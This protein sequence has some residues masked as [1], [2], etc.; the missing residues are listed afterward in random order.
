MG[1]CIPE[2]ITTF[3]HN[4]S[5]A[6]LA[7]HASCESPRHFSAKHHVEGLPSLSWG[8]LE[9]CLLTADKW[10]CCLSLKGSPGTCMLG[11]LTFYLPLSR[12]TRFYPSPHTTQ[13]G[14]G[15]Q[16]RAGETSPDDG[17]ELFLDSANA[18][19]SQPLSWRG[20]QAWSACS[21]TVTACCAAAVPPEALLPMRRRGACLAL[22]CFF[23]VSCG[24]G[25]VRSCAREGCC[26]V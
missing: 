23:R 16:Q 2:V 26:R 6:P 15:A 4:A 11:L 12:R 13:F 21:K 18:L 9:A 1:T 5:R 24:E 10:C 25:H 19:Q 8:L 22:A 20:G 14:V 7:M 3:L 17:P